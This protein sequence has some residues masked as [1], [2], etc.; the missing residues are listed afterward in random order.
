ML[1]PKSCA[2]NAAIAQ[3]LPN[4]ALCPCRLAPQPAGECDVWA[5][6]RNDPAPLT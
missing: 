3:V 6:H 2:A 4:N 5:F 1:P